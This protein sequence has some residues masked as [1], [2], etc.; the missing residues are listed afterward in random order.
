MMMSN[1]KNFYRQN[2]RNAQIGNSS[3]NKEMMEGLQKI[4]KSEMEI[5]TIKNL[6]Q[7][8]EVPNYNKPINQLRIRLKLI[9][10]DQTVK[11]IIEK[12]KVRMKDPVEKEKMLKHR[13]PNFINL[14]KANKLNKR[15]V[16]I[17]KR[18]SSRISTNNS[19]ITSTQSEIKIE[20]LFNPRI[21]Y[22]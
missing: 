1:K 9:K 20:K 4:F 10:P 5:A 13:V 11:G 12:Y 19:E 7:I 15:I 6:G 17:S 22:K 14:N 8:R 3:Q 2:R 18:A 21:G 16:K